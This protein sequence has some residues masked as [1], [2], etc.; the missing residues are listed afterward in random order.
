MFALRE[1][2]YARTHL[3]A[4]RLT[5]LLEKI[6]FT[7][8]DFEEDVLTD[9]GTSRKKRITFWIA[10]TDDTCDLSKPQWRRSERKLPSA[11]KKFGLDMKFLGA[12]NSPTY[13]PKREL[14]F[15][16]RKNE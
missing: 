9:S 2:V 1:L 5:N 16:V 14:P 13:S 12:E 7:P 11:D 6:V 4:E 10:L 8:K 15:Y 3:L